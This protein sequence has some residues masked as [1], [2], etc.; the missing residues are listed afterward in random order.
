MQGGLLSYQCRRKYGC[1]GSIQ[2][3]INSEHPENPLIFNGSL[4]FY[5][6]LIDDKT[7]NTDGKMSM[8]DTIVLAGLVGL[9]RWASSWTGH[10]AGHTSAGR[11]ACQQTPLFW[12][13]GQDCSSGAQATLLLCIMPHKECLQPGRRLGCCQLRPGWPGG[14]AQV[15]SAPMRSVHAAL[16]FW[17]KRQ[18][19]AC[20]HC[21]GWPAEVLPAYPN[22]ELGS[23]GGFP[24]QDSAISY[25]CV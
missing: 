20:L 23:C 19:T 7:I 5:R 8:A 17:L 12:L 2:F 3:E 21:I 13:A 24:C 22:T 4:Q 15:G 25:T 16:W 10:A 14:S 1:D 9:Q 11:I 6:S 18:G